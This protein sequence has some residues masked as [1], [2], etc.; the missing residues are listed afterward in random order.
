MIITLNIFWLGVY[1]L[2]TWRRLW[3]EDYLLFY[4][5]GSPNLRLC[6]NH[7]WPLD[8]CSRLP[9]NNPATCSGFKIW[10]SVSPV[11]R[12]SLSRAEEGLETSRFTTLNGNYEDLIWFCLVQ[13]GKVG[14]ILIQFV[15]VD[16]SFLVM[17]M[18][19]FVSWNI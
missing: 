15:S 12:S 7:G 5:V 13:I 6:R 9:C 19:I 18:E 3:N 4:F 14:N 16:G 17:G 1:V 10:W 2:V 8:H 11:Q